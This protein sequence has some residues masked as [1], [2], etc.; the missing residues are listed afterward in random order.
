MDWP[1]TSPGWDVADAGLQQAMDMFWG[2]IVWW[3]ALTLTL[4]I[5]GLAL[6]A[7]VAVSRVVRRRVWCAAA[8]REAEVDFVER[9][10]PSFTGRY[11][12]RAAAGS[13]RPR[14][15]DA[16]APVSTRSGPGPLQIERRYSA[17]ARKTSGGRPWISAPRIIP[18]DDAARTTAAASMDR[19]FQPM[20]MTPAR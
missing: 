4:V 16:S 7:A 10:V 9:G 15:C 1:M 6:L 14:T 20:R 19:Q 11:S 13:I 12:C 18:G 2:K 3:G 17:P 5:A 8:G